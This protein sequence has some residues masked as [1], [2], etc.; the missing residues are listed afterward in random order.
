MS[1]AQPENS[2]GTHLF[3]EPLPTTSKME[4]PDEP[5]FR[6]HFIQLST[7][8]ILEGYI[9]ALNNMCLQSTLASHH[10][11]QNVYSHASVSIA[12]RH[13]IKVASLYFVPSHA[14]VS[15]NELIVSNIYQTSSEIRQCHM[16]YLLNTF[17][18]SFRFDQSACT[19]TWEKTKR[20]ITSHMCTLCFLESLQKSELDVHVRRQHMGEDTS[21]A[22]PEQNNCTHLFSVPLLTASEREKPDEPLFRGRLS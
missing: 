9:T 8:R 11:L 4:K 15:T 7:S 5:L 21:A 19:I 1:S 16:V 12:N 2:N 22:Q 13:S 20:E 17:R 18:M 3:T 14:L 6:C 10:S